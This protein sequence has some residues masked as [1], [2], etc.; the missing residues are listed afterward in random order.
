MRPRN[1]IV[2]RSSPD[3]AHFDI[4]KSRQFLARIGLDENIIVDF[5]AIWDANF[6]IDFCQFRQRV[7]DIATRTLR[8]VGNAVLVELADFKPRSCA[9]DD[10]VVFI[11]DDDWLNS[12]L[13]D[14][15]RPGSSPDGAIWGSVVVGDGFL[16][17]G[18][19]LQRRRSPRSRH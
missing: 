2:R 3:W 4:E 9:D 7:K 17:P 10:L 6:A 5:A 14:A 15:I 1:I 18:N 11:D 16:G 12:G 19:R 8:S 13:V